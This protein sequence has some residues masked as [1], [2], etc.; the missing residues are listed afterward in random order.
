MISTPGSLS[1]ATQAC[2]KI[3]SRCSSSHKVS[4]DWLVTLLEN[5]ITN[6]RTIPLSLKPVA[7]A[8]Q[9]KQLQAYKSCYT[10]ENCLPHMKSPRGTGPC[11][12]ALREV[13][14]TIILKQDPPN[15][16]IDGGL[17]LHPASSTS[18]DGVLIA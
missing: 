8:T 12:L 14:K 3:A 4:R 2:A 7:A 17:C 9:L 16:K 5:S 1:F 11:R 10:T 6:N 13:V 15:H 18:K